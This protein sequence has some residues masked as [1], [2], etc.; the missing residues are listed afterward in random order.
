M[1]QNRWIRIVLRLSILAAVAAGCE[2]PATRI[3]VAPDGNDAWS[4]LR[5]TPNAEKTDG[6]LASLVG[7]RDAVRRLKQ[8]EGLR[9]PVRVI[10]RDGTYRITEPLLLTPEDSGTAKC[11]ITYESEFAATI[12]AGVPITGFKQGDD[13]VW[14]ARVPE[15]DGKPIYFEQ[16]YVNGSWATRARSPNKYYYYVKRKVTHA[17]D[18]ATGK[19]ANM[20]H[21][22]FIA[23]AEDVEPLLSI[24]KDRLSDVT[25]MAY[26]SW[27]CSRHRVASIDPK[28]H[29]LVTTGPS[30]WPFCR[31]NANQRYHLENFRAAL[32]QPGEWFLDRDGTLF[33]KPR[34][35]EDMRKAN[36]V[37]PVCDRFL[38]I[39][40][41]PKLGLYVEHVTLTPPSESSDAGPLQ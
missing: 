2:A 40:G 39:A 27:A 28:T 10:V 25:M 21:R 22:A 33:Y 37:A 18:P 30:R 9:L 29:L 23:R 36:V 19:P 13:G 20:S 26:H 34:P 41:E 4:G 16:L 32:D 8:D 12:T 11:P 1:R 3:Y 38:R 17:I 14:T 35:D 15:V 5:K 31:W 6:P 7:A 24:P